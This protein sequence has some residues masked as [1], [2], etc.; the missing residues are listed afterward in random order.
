MTD[1]D[2][3]MCGTSTVEPVFFE[4]WIRPGMHLSAI[5]G[6][7]IEP[8]AI[9]RADRVV[10]HTNVE[11]PINVFSKALHAPHG[12]RGHGKAKDAVDLRK[13]PMLWSMLAGQAEKRK[14]DDEVT[15]LINAQGIGYQFAAAG[16]AGLQQGQGRWALGQELPTDWFTEDVPN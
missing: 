10:V 9:R 6:E 15:C 3:A 1:V 12:E 8:A 4:R 2:I 7:E 5:K 14:S 13:L 16:I 11:P